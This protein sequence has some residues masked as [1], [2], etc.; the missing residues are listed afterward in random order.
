MASLHVIYRAAADPARLHAGSAATSLSSLATA[1]PLSLHRWALEFA[2]VQSPAA[3]CRSCLQSDQALPYA[4][5]YIYIH[6]PYITQA[7][8]IEKPN[9][10]FQV[11]CWSVLA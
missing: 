2:F 6:T 1:Q 8:L 5:T 7:L 4:H 10:V 11:A 3:F 9:D